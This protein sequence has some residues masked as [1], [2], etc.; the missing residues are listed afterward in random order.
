MSKLGEVVFCLDCDRNV[1]R[2]RSAVGDEAGRAPPPP[3]R[4]AVKK[5]ANG[6]RLCAPCLD[7]RRSNRN[8]LFLLHEGRAPLPGQGPTGSGQAPGAEAPAR[9]RILRIASA[10]RIPRSPVAEVPASAP[11]SVATRAERPS[12]IAEVAG[13]QPVRAKTAKTAKTKKALAPERRPDGRASDTAPPRSAGAV[14]LQERA[15]M[16]LAL[17]L[18]F[19][20]TRAL[21][22]QLKQKLRSV[23]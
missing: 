6:D 15:F 19:I 13:S 21:L 16:Q 20:R 12:G 23:R 22:A 5:D 3:R 4:M 7:S 17:E 18:G 2:Y 11:A 10:V 8:A 9:Q 14:P 1:E